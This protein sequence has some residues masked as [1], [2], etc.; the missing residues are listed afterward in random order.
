M[1]LKQRQ[2]Q[3]MPNR[4]RQ[5]T[6]RGAP[7][8]AGMGQPGAGWCIA[9]D[10]IMLV[11]VIISNFYCFTINTTHNCLTLCNPGAAAAGVR[12]PS[13][14][15]S[16]HRRAC[17]ASGGGS[18]PGGGAHTLR[19]YRTFSPWHGTLASTMATCYTWVTR[20]MHAEAVPVYSQALC[21]RQARARTAFA[22]TLRTLL[23]IMY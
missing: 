15:T 3:A 9:M 14:A 22:A 4:S 19:V 6:L 18:L 11:C 17:A 13:I 23:F 2:K 10:M 20:A 7:A 16:H 21:R 1:Q 8:A 5:R 12:S